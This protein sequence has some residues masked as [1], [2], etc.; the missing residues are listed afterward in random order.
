MLLK[1][2][3][4]RQLNKLRFNFLT[5]LLQLGRSAATRSLFHKTSR[6]KSTK[7]T[8]LLELLETIMEEGEEV[9]IFSQFV[10]LIRILEKNCRQQSPHLNP[11][12]QHRKSR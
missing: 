9:L 12:G 8:T 2:K 5:S 3:T 7:I 1:A 10:E 6:A 4:Q 11:C